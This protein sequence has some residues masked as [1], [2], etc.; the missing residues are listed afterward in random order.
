MRRESVLLYLS[1]E[2]WCSIIKLIPVNTL[3]K[4]RFLCRRFQMIATLSNKLNHYRKISHEIFNTEK[5]YDL[6]I[7]TYNNVLFQRF[8]YHFSFSTLC[9]LRYRTQFIK[10]QFLCSRYRTQFIKNQFLCSSVLSHI[11]D[12]PRSEFA[13]NNC[14]C[15]SRLQVNPS[16]FF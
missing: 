13:I 2:I 3:S 4:L 7:D 5:L 14:H 11:F 10:N 12:C 9:Y 6:F 1:I 8:N 16:T 15:C